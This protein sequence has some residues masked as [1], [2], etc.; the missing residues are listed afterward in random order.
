ML[1]CLGGSQADVTF[2]LFQARAM[3]G[4][5]KKMH[6]TFF[7]LMHPMSYRPQAYDSVEH[8]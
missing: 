1:L 7:C 2:A 3:P 6:P 8:R 4:I 5:E